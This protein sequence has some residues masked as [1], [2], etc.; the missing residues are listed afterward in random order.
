MKRMWINQP[1]TWQAQHALHGKNVLAL[2]DDTDFYRVY[3]TEGPIVSTVIS[4]LCLSN[5]W[6]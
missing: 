6:R 5:G 3:F 2:V 1:S 4:K